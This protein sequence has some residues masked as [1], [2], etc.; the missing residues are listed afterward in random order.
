MLITASD[1][2]HKKLIIYLKVSKCY[3]KKA[4][5]GKGEEKKLT[6]K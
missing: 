1:I 5:K 4:E 2:G 3:K 6:S